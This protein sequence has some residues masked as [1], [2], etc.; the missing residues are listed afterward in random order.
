MCRFISKKLWSARKIDSGFTRPCSSGDETTATLRGFD[1]YRFRDRNLLLLQAEFRQHLWAQFDATFFV[2]TGKVTHDASQIGLSGLK[3]D[4]GISISFMRVDA[5]II[6]F[7]FAF[8]GGEGGHS[9]L[10]P[11][12]SFLL[13]ADS[14]VSR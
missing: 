6:R 14:F 10:T 13:R 3:H 1:G 12:A 2:D 8:A 9:F 11:V 5:T 7:D 4:V